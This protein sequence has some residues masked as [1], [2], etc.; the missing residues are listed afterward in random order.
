MI[1]FKNLLIKFKNSNFSFNDPTRRRRITI[2]D[3]SDNFV[4]PYRIAFVISEFSATERTTRNGISF[5]VFAKSEQQQLLAKEN[6]IFALETTERVFEL[7]SELFEIPLQFQ[8]LDEVALPH[9]H[10]CGDGESYGIAFYSEKCLLDFKNVSCDL[11]LL[12]L[13]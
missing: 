4:S 13:L 8:T 2:F 12:Q 10:H 7:F 9:S 1:N 5:R 3:Q 11:K 6:A